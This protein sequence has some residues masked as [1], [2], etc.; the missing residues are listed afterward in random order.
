ME[1]PKPIGLYTFIEKLT[2]NTENSTQIPNTFLIDS[3][4]TEYNKITTNKGVVNMKKATARM[5]AAAI[6]LSIAAAGCSDI[7][8]DLPVTEITGTAIYESSDD[9]TETTVL[10]DLSTNS[11]ESGE[12]VERS[13]EISSAASSS[14]SA[15]DSAV[16][17]GSASTEQIVTV[18]S[19]SSL[20]ILDTSD[21]FSDRDL[22]QTAD[23]S[24]SKTITVEDGK[25]IEITEEGVYVVTGSAKNCTIKV[26]ADK[27]AKV[28]LVLD[29][30][31]ITNDSFPAIYVVS[32]DK[33]FVT[34][35]DTVNT[36][37]VTGAFVSD[38]AT[39]TDAVVFSKDDLVLNGTG[40]LSISSSNGNGISSKD[41]LRITGGTYNI[42]SAKDSIEANDSI[43][44]CGG[45]FN[46]TSGKDGLHSEND[47]DNSLGY[48]YISDGS[49]TINAASDA[50]QGTTIIQIDG[51]S[52][53]LSGSECIEGTYVQING[54]NISITA[55]DDGI[56]AS[57]KS[58]AYD[59]VIEI[60]GGELTIS[61]GQGDTDAIDA[62]GSI[63]VNG[64]YIDISAGMSSFDYDREAQYNGGTI[65]I[66]GQQVSEIPSEM[67][68]GR[69]GM[70]NMSNMGAMN[71]GRGRV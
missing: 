4:K 34:T 39:N 32:V 47:D 51:G 14:S 10:K 42:T 15:T 49:F 19:G 53:T 62:N 61:M 8:S 52:F 55:T 23:L 71:G 5:I 16:Q 38:D 44:I 56:N 11:N 54:G 29:G 17:S 50:I 45:T 40:T 35:T 69:G 3:Q 28:Q 30:V 27:E 13:S 31:T 22:S 9:N 46:V 6:M 33:C 63:Y 12:N 66:N 59:V 60:N 57:S 68:G 20:G 26:S 48:I 25:T 58:S 43:H 37:S 41:D 7:G 24:D 1:L 36:L 64:G 65:I 2:F 18:F 21:M 70:G 67:M